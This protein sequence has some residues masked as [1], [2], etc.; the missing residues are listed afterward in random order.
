MDYLGH[1]QKLVV[2]HLQLLRKLNI[3]VTKKHLFTSVHHSC[4]AHRNSEDFFFIIKYL[5][6]FSKDTSETRFLGISVFLEV[7]EIYKAADNAG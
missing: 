3:L 7:L 4:S 1:N 6:V 2:F 5:A